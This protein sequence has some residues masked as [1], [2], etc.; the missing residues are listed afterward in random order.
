MNMMCVLTDVCATADR[1]VYG[2][3]VL[4][5]GRIEPSLSRVSQIEA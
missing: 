3:F 5:G 2:L 1:L 4:A